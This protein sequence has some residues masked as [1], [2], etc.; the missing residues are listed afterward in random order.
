LRSPT[1]QAK[2]Q[3]LKNRLIE[4]NDINAAAG[5]LH[6]D[7]STYMPPGGAKARARQT[8][9]LSRLAHEKF[10]DVAIGN[11]L[12]T[13]TPYEKSLDY[14]SDEASLIRLTRRKYERAIK[15]PAKFMA[16]V[17]THTSES[18]Q[19]WTKARPAN[20]FERVRPYLEKTLEYSRKCANFFPGYDHI[21]DPLIEPRDFGMKAADVSRV[22]SELRKELVPIASAITSQ[23]P[24]DDSCLHKHYPE[25]QQLDFGMVVAKK[26]GYDLNRGRQDKTHHPFMTKFSLGDVRITTRSKEDSLG[27]ALF[28]TMHETGHALYEQGINMDFEGTPLARGTSAGV[29]ESQSRLWENIVG[30]SKGFWNCFYPQLQKTFSEQLLPVSADEFHRA[31]NK[32]ERSLIRTEADEVTYNLHVMLRFDFELA[33][34]EGEMEIRDLPSAWRERFEAD[35]GIVPPDDKDGVLQDVHWYFGLIGGSFQGY[36][37]GN[38]LAAQFYTSALES[39]PEIPNDIEKGEFQTL[40]NWL[41]NNIYRH[42]SKFTA[43]EIIKRATGKPMSIKPYINYLRTKYGELYSLN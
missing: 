19:V 27:E 11:L 29:H 15:I 4:V 36:T 41:R 1:L 33:L 22:F 43:P 38:I 24:A 23:P 28:C 14:E 12:D 17:A 10:T 5:V 3:E 8:A 7:Q 13:L 26:F 9:T 2:F 18:Y 32:V 25:T 35:F 42:G 34:L 31:I 6:W 37:L 40:H 39:H 30:R 20:D 21:A 16:E